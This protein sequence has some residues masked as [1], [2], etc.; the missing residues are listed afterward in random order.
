MKKMRHGLKEAK[1]LKMLR[2]ASGSL[3]QAT[4]SSP[5]ETDPES[6]DFPEEST[7][8]TDGAKL[9]DDNDD[10]ND[11]DDDDD[12]DVDD[13]GDVD[14]IVTNELTYEDENNEDDES[15]VG[16]NV[17]DELNDRKDGDDDDDNLDEENNE[18]MEEAVG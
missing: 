10:Q 2:G 14:D 6:Q 15:D 7:D 12:D 18:V 9:F 16:D 17:S 11:E 4:E 5:M 8:K 3:N 1:Y 13:F